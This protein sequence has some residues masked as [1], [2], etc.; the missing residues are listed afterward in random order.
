M[1]CYG[2]VESVCDVSPGKF[3][4]GECLIMFFFRHKSKILTHTH[5]LYGAFYETGAL[6]RLSLTFLEDCKCSVR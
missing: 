4:L 3:S 6:S 5:I 2:E 1:H